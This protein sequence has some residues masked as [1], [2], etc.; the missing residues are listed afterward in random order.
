MQSKSFNMTF[1]YQKSLYLANKDIYL[2]KS[3]LVPCK[4]I[5]GIGTH[6]LSYNI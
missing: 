5:L 4:R 2:I 1:V 3:A 6:D